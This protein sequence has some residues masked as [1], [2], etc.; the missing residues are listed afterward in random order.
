MKENVVWVYEQKQAFSKMGIDPIKG[1]L[2]YGPPGTGKTMLAK[3][4]ATE[5]SATFINTEISQIINAYVCLLSFF[6]LYQLDTDVW[7]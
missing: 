4:I 2:L 3:A 5:V 7:K 6:I 1:V